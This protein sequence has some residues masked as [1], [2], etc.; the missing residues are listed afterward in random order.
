M[1]SSTTMSLHWSHI[2][3]E[4]QQK[5]VLAPLE[6][7]RNVSHLVG[8]EWPLGDVSRIPGPNAAIPQ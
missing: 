2:P 5:F 1:F 4:V 3:N 8:S 6:V 7:A